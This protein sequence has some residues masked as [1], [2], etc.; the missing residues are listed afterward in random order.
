MLVRPAGVRWIAAA[1]LL[2]S[3]PLGVR[4]APAPAGSIYPGIDPHAV[5]LYGRVLDVRDAL[6][7]PV[8]AGLVGVQVKEGMAAAAVQAAFSSRL[9]RVRF[10]LMALERLSFRT[11]ALSR[12]SPRPGV[13]VHDALPPCPRPDPRCREARCAVFRTDPSVHSMSPAFPPERRHLSRAS[14]D[15]LR[16]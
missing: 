14:S 10:V 11:R 8:S 1:C 6:N 16:C 15:V 3:C 4:A 2:A 13:R 5:L 12:A 7:R 9:P